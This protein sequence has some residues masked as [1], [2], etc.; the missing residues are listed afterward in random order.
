MKRIVVFGALFLSA[1]GPGSVNVD[2]AIVGTDVRPAMYSSAPSKNTTPYDGVFA[3]YGKLLGNKKLSVAVGDIRDYTGK[4]SD[5]EGLLITQGGSLMAYT[6]LGK[7]A[8]GVQLHE[9]FDTRIADAELAWINARQLGDGTQNEIPN[10]ES[11]TTET[12]PWL[13]YYG[14]SV[15]QSEYYIVGGI[16][17]LNFNIRSGGA[18]ALISNLGPRSRTYVMNIAVDLRIVG[19]QS[20]R[21]YE[22]VSVQKQLVGYEVDFEV[23]RFFDNDLFDVNLGAKNNEPLQFG[24][25]VA[26][27]EALLKLVQSVSKVPATP[28]LSIPASPTSAEAEATVR[29]DPKG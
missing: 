5:T 18:E 29:R 25:R 12:V 15:L 13:P 28:C 10:A 2:R 14:G 7:M 17:E 1:C 23:F 8:P 26:I 11:G 20:L 9:R 3:C 24:V 21:V 4:N 16:T 6:G 22:T 27:E 19:T